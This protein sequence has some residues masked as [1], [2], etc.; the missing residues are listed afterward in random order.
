MAD[1]AHGA[2]IKAYSSGVTT[3][4]CIV[5]SSYGL[6][7]AGHK[8][9][10]LFLMLLKQNWHICTTWVSESLCVFMATRAYLIAA[11]AWSKVPVGKIELFDAEGTVNDA[12]AVRDRRGRQP[13]LWAMTW[14]GTVG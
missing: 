8:L 11:R 2:D 4:H 12:L 13:G 14:E 7:H 6:R 10:M 9:F 1:K 5:F 3:F